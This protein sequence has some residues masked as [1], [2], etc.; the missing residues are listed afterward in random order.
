MRG[1]PLHRVFSGDQ[2]GPLTGG[3]PSGPPP[4]PVHP[5]V[6]QRGGGLPLPPASI[7]IHG[8][9]PSPPHLRQTL[10]IMGEPANRHVCLLPLPEASPS[11]F[12]SPEPSSGGSGCLPSTMASQGS[13]PLFPHKIVIQVLLKFRQSLAASA[14]LIAPMWPLQSWFP[15]LLDLA[16]A[17]PRLLPPWKDLLVSSVDRA[18]CLRPGIFHLAGWRLSSISFMRGTFLRTLRNSSPP[19]TE[20]PPLNY[21]ATSGEC[22]R[23]GAV[24]GISIPLLP[25]FQTY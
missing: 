16:V 1:R 15:D 25:L 2:R 14:T 9:I 7:S 22:S 4:P 5:G 20:Y 13:L 18:A 23:A 12:P 10:E 11:T 24:N 8:V 3:V 6:S 21:T 17:P 19:A